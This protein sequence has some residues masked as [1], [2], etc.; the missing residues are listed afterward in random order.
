MREV[1][2]GPGHAF[3]AG[4]DWRL[5][6]DGSRGQPDLLVVD[7]SEPTMRQGREIERIQD[8]FPDA[9][10]MLV[11]EADRIKGLMDRFKSG[12]REYLAKPVDGTAFEVAVARVMEKRSLHTRVRELEDTIE[13]YPEQSAADLLETERFIVVKQLV[14]KLSYFIAQIAQDVEDGVKYF[15]STPYF[16]AIHNCDQQIIANDGMFQKYFGNRVGS[17][18]WEI[19]YGKTASPEHCP[20]GRT[21]ETGMVQRIPA[22]VRYS[23]G[24]KTPVIAHTAPIYNNNGRMAL[25]LEVMTGT[26]EI[27]RLRKELR[28]TQQKYQKLFDEV[29]DY[30]A[31][32]DRKF[33]VNAVNRRFKDEFGDPAGGNFFDIFTKETFS[34]QDCPPVKTLADGGS[35]QVETELITRDGRRFKAIL[36]SS[37]V[38]THTGKIIQ[39]IVIFKDVTELRQLEDNLSTLG[40]M[41][42][43]ISHNIKN[44]LTGLDAGLYHID[45]GFYKNVPGEIEEG[46]EVAGLMVERIRKLILDVLYYAKPRELQLQRVDVADLIDEVGRQIQ[47]KMGA[48]NIAFEYRLTGASVEFEV[49]PEIFRSILINLLENAMEACMDPRVDRECYVRFTAETAADQVRFDVIDNGCGMDASQ[50]NKIFSKFYSSKG[51]KGTGLGLFIARQVIARHGGNVEVESSPGEGSHFTLTMPL[52]PQQSQNIE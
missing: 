38:T 16:V 45:R 24:E 25:I 31:V 9:E 27:K 15:H 44:V 42:S 4:T 39:V 48:R 13:N 21:I 20:V 26:R 46:M 5:L 19:Y 32:L 1:I 29:P 7:C 14:D 8:R 23:S 18:S 28:T 40:L 41:F 36:S 33:R 22:V 30:I 35:H 11:A 3:S 43:V 49:D 52:H 6:E 51:H 12:I 50:K 37:P 34:G 2:E 17:N 10:I 47:P